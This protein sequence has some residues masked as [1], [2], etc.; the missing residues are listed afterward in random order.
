MFEKSRWILFAF[1]TDDLERLV[2][3][4]I[5]L[6]Q[7]IFQ[8]HDRIGGNIKERVLG[9]RTM[10]EFETYLKKQYETKFVFNDVETSFVRR[11]ASFGKHVKTLV[12]GSTLGNI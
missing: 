10:E 11:Q 3:L 5:K 1:W 4:E 6:A 12:K 2:R 9:G 7:I 8:L